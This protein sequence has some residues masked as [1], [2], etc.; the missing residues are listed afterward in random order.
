MF[1]M[2]EAVHKRAEMPEGSLPIQSRMRKADLKRREDRL[3]YQQTT[4]LV[5]CVSHLTP[6]EQYMK[7]E[8]LFKIVFDNADND[9][10]GSGNKYLDKMEFANIAEPLTYG[11]IGEDNIKFEEKILASKD[12]YHKSMHE[13]KWNWQN[14]VKTEKGRVYWDQFKE[15][16]YSPKQVEKVEKNGLREVFL[17]FEMWEVPTFQQQFME[18]KDRYLACFKKYDADNKGFLNVEEQG[19]VVEVLLKHRPELKEYSEKIDG[20]KDGK[21][22]WAEFWHF[23]STGILFATDDEGLD[24]AHDL[25]HD[26]EVA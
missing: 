9:F 19:Q 8:P 4:E 21:V 13:S 7:M 16:F 14:M 3:I 26:W 10:D 20:D 2:P 25:L 11:T 5:T 12:C 18:L 15:F 23:F 1:T 6:V 22:T 17:A 24:L